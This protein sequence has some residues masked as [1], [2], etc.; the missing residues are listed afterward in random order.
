MTDDLLEQFILE[1][2]ELLQGAFDD[3][4]ALE[5]A[6]WDAAR[7]DSAF[8]A[9]HT[10][11]GSAGLFDFEP[12]STILHGA[13]DLL[14][15]LRDNRIPARAEAVD[16]LLA[17]LNA[18]D[19]WIAAI[20]DV[21][22]LP[23]DA[24]TQARRLVD[25]LQAA[26]Q[27]NPTAMRVAPS[28]APSSAPLGAP[29]PEPGW[30]TALMADHLA[31]AD[32]ARAGQ[33]VQTGIRYRPHA[34]CFF[35]GD[36]PIALVRT[37]PD[38]VALQ[39][40]PL[41]PW[42]LDSL[43][44][45]RCNLVFEALSAAPVDAVTRIF[46]FV[47]DQVEIIAVEAAL[48]GVPPTG[49]AA[50]PDPV[51]GGTQ[52]LLRIDADRIDMM[53]D[54]VGELFIAKN[55]LSH[56]TAEAVATAPSLAR[57]LSVNHADIERL[58]AD[59][60]RAVMGVRMVALGQVFR[61]LPRIVR[62]IAG[63]LGKDIR[64]DIEGGDTLADKTIVDALFEPLL[65]VVRNAADH[66]IEPPPIREAA[67]KPRDGR[68]S[69]N[70]SRNGEKIVVEIN[71]DGAGIDPATIR[72][73]A[74]ARGLLDPDALAALSN[75]DVL[76]LVFRPG[77]STA[78]SITDISGRGVGM[79]AVRAALHAMGGRVHIQ[80]APGAGTSCTVRCAAGRRHHHRHRRAGRRWPLRHPGRDN[81]RNR[82]HPPDPC[83][84]GPGRRSFRP[85]RPHHSPATPV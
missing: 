77:F 71:D 61:R 70:A 43:D 52:R 3:L 31:S 79:D 9:V 38:L 21:G 36:D 22:H 75:A 5:Q 76:D 12:L 53:A 65:H 74:A 29:H 63:R 25:G 67:G 35:L 4:L 6:E 66:G 50:V 57:A 24:A 84:T 56:L 46:R 1:G 18:T 54:I 59:L 85:A 47:T 39:I 82:A 17:V 58:V 40:R 8:R 20:A 51:A 11:K 7:V 28:G 14:D 45:H 72:R 26:P 69:V 44:P 13:E 19:A 73:I 27:S 55:R 68:I 48:S 34:D 64:L 33:S 2:Q 80:A 16:A 41:E 42:V 83:A 15:G 60:H 32:R 78:S 10:L 23:D 49:P 37:I 30:L 81:R 62:D